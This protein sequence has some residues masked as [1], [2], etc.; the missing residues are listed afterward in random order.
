MPH[1]PRFF[2]AFFLAFF[3]AGALTSMPVMA[4]NNPDQFPLRIHIFQRSEHTHFRHGVLDFAQ[5]LGRANLY[6]NGQPLGFDFSFEC[7]ERVMTSAGYETYLARWKKKGLSLE[8]LVPVIGKPGAT[9]GCELKVEMKDF[10]YFHHAGAL[11][12][13]PPTAFR[14]WMEKHQYDPE[15][16]KNEPVRS[17]TGE[18]EQAPADPSQAPIPPPPPPPDAPQ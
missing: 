8:I 9:H 12:T 15:H 17:Q 5:G 7:G 11:Y 13:E 3:L 14:Q 4:S 2:R 6:E 1:L 16:G 10:A 18:S